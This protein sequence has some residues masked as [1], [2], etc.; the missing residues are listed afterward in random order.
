VRGSARLGARTLAEGPFVAA[1]DGQGAVRWAAG[2]EGEIADVAVDRSGAVHVAAKPAKSGDL[3]LIG[4]DDRGSVVSRS[5]VPMDWRGLAPALDARGGLVWVK[6]PDPKA[7]EKV[8]VIACDAAGHERWRRPVPNMTGDCTLA[9]AGDG[10]VIAAC[11][12]SAHE[13][14]PA[15]RLVWSAATSW[16][17]GYSDGNVTGVAVDDTSVTT[18]VSCLGTRIGTMMNSNYSRAYDAGSVRV[19][20]FSRR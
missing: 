12:R 18:A 11:P 15:G 16:Y 2:V 7:G 3:T 1:V 17:C 8:E 4:L 20:R 10:A 14:D 9:F 13:I 5:V 6:D 19:T